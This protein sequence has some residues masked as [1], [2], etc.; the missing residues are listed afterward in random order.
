MYVKAN[1]SVLQ[2]QQYPQLPAA[3]IQQ[4][5]QIWKM[6]DE[7]EH[8]RRQAFYREVLSQQQA[9]SN[10]RTS[11]NTQHTCMESINII[12]SPQLTLD[13]QAI[14]NR[15]RNQVT[16]VNVTPADQSGQT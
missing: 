9:V 15:R 8:Q 11:T 10:R 4:K 7:R 1:L 16:Q 12:T 6:N 3:M 13:I 2:Q 5:A 14:L